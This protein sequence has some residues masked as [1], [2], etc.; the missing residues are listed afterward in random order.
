MPANKNRKDGKSSDTVSRLRFPKKEQNEQF[1]IVTQLMGANQVKVM[2]QDGVER[3]CRI[4][5]KLRK[6]VWVRVN[7]L[8]IVQ[9]WD[10]QPSKADIKWRFLGNQVEWFRRKGML[11]GLSI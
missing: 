11:E 8:V 9:V 3:G 2:C 5:G 7:D 1:G 4:P 6:R 10:F